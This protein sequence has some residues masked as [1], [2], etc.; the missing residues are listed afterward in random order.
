MACAIVLETAPDSLFYGAN[1]HL[2][3][4]LNYAQMFMIKKFPPQTAKHREL[5][6]DLEGYLDRL[7]SRQYPA[8]FEANI[9]EE[10]DDVVFQLLRSGLVGVGPGE[11]ELSVSPS[12][13][14]GQ[15]PPL[16][17]RLVFQIITSVHPDLPEPLKEFLFTLIESYRA[18]G[19]R[20]YLS[21]GGLEKGVLPP[22]PLGRDQELL[23]RVLELREA[24]QQLAELNAEPGKEYEEFE[25][26][27]T[28]HE[29]LRVMRKKRQI[30]SPRRLEKDSLAL[31]ELSIKPKRVRKEKNSW[32][33]VIKKLVKE[34]LLSYPISHQALKKM[35][36]KKFPWIDWDKV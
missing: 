17:V 29:I 32:N 33:A 7:A 21:R 2:Y 30:H 15:H 9:R 8:E 3:I 22:I 28:V 24:D 16:S 18:L 26:P 4:H 25:E 36:N 13:A 14:N 19:Q 12:Q 34:R 35:L 5:V 31:S 27:A 20:D 10:L 23:L 11:I 1:I 6:E